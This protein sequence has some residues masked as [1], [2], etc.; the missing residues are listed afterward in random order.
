MVVPNNRV[1]TVSLR[2]TIPGSCRSSDPPIDNTRGASAR[3]K[4]VRISLRG[5]TAKGKVCAAGKIIPC[6]LAI[7]LLFSLLLTCLVTSGLPH[8]AGMGD[9]EPPGMRERG[10]FGGVKLTSP[11]LITLDYSLTRSG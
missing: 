7:T 6:V 11:T 5:R 4:R 3:S 8:Q 9:P 1:F 2:W 10:D